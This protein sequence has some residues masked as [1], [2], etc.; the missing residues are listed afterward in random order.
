[1]NEFS[2]SPTSGAQQQILAQTSTTSINT[3]D[4]VGSFQSYVQSSSASTLSPGNSVGASS[5]AKKN[6]KHIAQI[7]SI[8][9][10]AA[11]QLRNIVIV[12]NFNKYFKYLKKREKKSF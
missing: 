4:S 12:R 9:T 11:N 7:S 2:T 8:F 5:R 3:R 10:S 1:M 6:F